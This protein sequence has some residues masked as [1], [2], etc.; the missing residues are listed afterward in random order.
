MRLNLRFGLCQ[1][2]FLNKDLYPRLIFIIA[3]PIAVINMQDRFQISQ[4][5]SLGDEGCDFLTNYR[6]AAK[7]AANQ[8]AIASLSSFILPQLYADIMKGNHRSVLFGCRDSNF[9]F[10]GQEGK[11]RMAG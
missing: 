2:Q 9:E 7:P 4:K 3:P 10:P 5:L 1:P 8:N 11:F 6:G